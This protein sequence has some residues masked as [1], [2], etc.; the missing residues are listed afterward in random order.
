MLE[1][2]EVEFELDIEEINARWEALSGA[3]TWSQM[4][5]KETSET[6][7][8]L[9]ATPAT[10]QYHLDSNGALVFGRAAV[11]WHMLQNESEAFFLR[12]YGP[13]DYRWK[14][15]DLGILVTK[16]RLQVRRNGSPQMSIRA[17]HFID[18]NRAGFT[19][20]PVDGGVQHELPAF[21]GIGVKTRW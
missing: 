20:L 21:A 14:G 19:G 13:G 7:E 12:I 6:V 2:M 16:G 9:T 18:S 15:G 3:D 11:D 1:F 10:G 4:I 17:K 8:L 5:I